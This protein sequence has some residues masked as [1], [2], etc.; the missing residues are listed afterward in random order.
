M[1]ERMDIDKYFREGSF[2]TWFSFFCILFVSYI[3]GIIFYNTFFINSREGNENSKKGKIIFSSFW[4]CVSLGFLFLSIDEL[5]MVHESTEK[6][7][8]Q[9]YKIKDSGVG[10]EI[11]DI[12][13]LSCAVL[14][15]FFI[16]FSR[17]KLFF[18]RKVAYFLV[19]IVLFFSAMM[20]FDY[21]GKGVK[22]RD[23]RSELTA[24]EESFKVI[25][26][27]FI[28]LA[29]L[30]CLKTSERLKKGEE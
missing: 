15:L 1:D 17:K 25:T 9:T 28:I 11:D 19:L 4:L 29:A 10:S 23:D 21:E 18:F 3:T 2:V 8:Q 24:Y 16:Y 6:I 22:D 7:L 14:G 5:L 13:V 20:I 27:G 26:E 12:F 30:H